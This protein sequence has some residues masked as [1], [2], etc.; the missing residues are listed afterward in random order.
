[1]TDVMVMNGYLDRFLLIKESTGKRER[2]IGAF[3]DGEICTYVHVFVC[4]PANEEDLEE[5]AD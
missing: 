2:E 5:I 4:S 1:M 3:G